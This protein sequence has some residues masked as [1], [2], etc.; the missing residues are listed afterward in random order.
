MGASQHWTQVLKAITGE[1][2]MSANALLEYF[3]PLSDFLIEE[4][5]RLAKE[6]EMRQ[7]LDKYSKEASNMCT[8]VT[9]AEWNKITDIN[10]NDKS[11]IYAKTVAENAKFLK[12]KYN[13]LFK[14]SKPEHFRD[15]KIQRQI[16]TIT[17]L[18]TSA[19]NDTQLNQLTNVKLQMEKIYNNAEFCSYDKPD[20]TKKLTLDPGTFRIQ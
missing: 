9:T 7:T 15:E 2:E 3:K 6:D 4:N 11:D 20:C 10:N 14:G 5:Q 17:N 12:D 8:K 1:T 18:G 16:R 19:L 13:E